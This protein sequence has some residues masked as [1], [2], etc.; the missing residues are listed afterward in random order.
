M[1]FRPWRLRHCVHPIIFAVFFCIFS[2]FYY[3]AGGTNYYKV[4]IIVLVG[5]DVDA[6]VV[7]DVDNVLFYVRPA[8]LGM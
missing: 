8:D 3:L 4:I 5:V 2:L 7:G 1:W 6:G